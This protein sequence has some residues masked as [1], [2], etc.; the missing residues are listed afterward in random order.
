MW[1]VG[2]QSSSHAP[3]RLPGPL[4][5]LDVNLRNKRRRTSSLSLA[6]PPSLKIPARVLEC[7][8]SCFTDVDKWA[9]Q[10]ASGSSE[11]QP[12]DLTNE[13]PVPPSSE[14]EEAKPVIAAHLGSASTRQKQQSPVPVTVDDS[15]T[16][17]LSPAQQRVLD[18]ILA[19][20]NIFF[21][22]PAG[23]GKSAVIRALTKVVFEKFDQSKTDGTDQARKRLR[24][25]SS[26][27]QRARHRC[28]A[29]PTV[30]DGYHSQ[31]RQSRSV[32]CGSQHLSELMRSTIGGCTL[33]SWAGIGLGQSDKEELLADV[34]RA[35]STK[36]R[37]QSTQ[38]L[39]IDESRLPFPAW[40]AHPQ[41]R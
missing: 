22:G 37:W 3:S 24:G 21:T 11:T 31:H 4:D 35:K 29:P 14:L 25:R 32:S 36:R 1:L 8:R 40:H 19:G 23:T 10:V 9:K 7:R 39:V 41:S 26:G 34:R 17:E 16:F 27:T 20:D 5:P 38:I 15:D 2:N 13:D 33:N 18:R 30:G 12:I 28:D 6:P